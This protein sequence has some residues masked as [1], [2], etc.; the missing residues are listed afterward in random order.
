MS[1]LGSIE[2]VREGK[3]VDFYL[4]AAV[5]NSAHEGSSSVSQLVSE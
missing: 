2:E 4:T 1:A 5:K 3:W